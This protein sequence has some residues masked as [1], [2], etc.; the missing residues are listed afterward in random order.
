M[1][2]KKFELA[3]S[4]QE[5]RQQLQGFFERAAKARCRFDLYCEKIG[6]DPNTTQAFWDVNLEILI[7]SPQFQ[8]WVQSVKAT[9]QLPT[10]GSTK[11]KVALD[12]GN[13][14]FKIPEKKD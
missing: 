13:I 4:E 12:F 1:P 2:S 10:Q 14:T 7:N 11:D 5:V 3:K 9:F 6:M 8:D